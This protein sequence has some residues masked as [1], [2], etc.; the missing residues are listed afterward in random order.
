MT[1]AIAQVLVRETVEENLRD[2]CRMLDVAAQ[3]RADLIVFP[4]MSM[5][6]YTR[7][8]AAELAF[9]VDDAGLDPLKSAAA[10][11]HIIAV[12]GAPVRMNGA[13]HIGSF[14]LFPDHSRSLYVK[15]FLHPGEELHFSSSFDHDPLIRAGGERISLAICADIDHPDHARQA[16]DRRSSV[17][18]A[19]IFFTPGGTA[20][21]HDRMRACASTHSMDILISNY[22]GPVCNMDSGG[23]SAY[24]SRQGELVGALQADEPGLLLVEKAQGGWSCEAVPFSPTP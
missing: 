20:E 7:E 22:C 2:H 18:A 14:I 13:L 15:R 4:E 1:F 19:S 5:T 3:H 16:S 21:A 24:W 10:A 8:K 6:G 9:D 12:A 17:Y 23:G 11:Q